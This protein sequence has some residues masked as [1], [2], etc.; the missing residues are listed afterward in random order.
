MENSEE[1]SVNYAYIA[2]ALAALSL[3]FFSG[4]HTF[5]RSN[6]WCPACGNPLVCKASCG[7]RYDAPRPLGVGLGVNRG[8]LDK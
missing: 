5:E 6:R 1:E 8:S 4:M 2:I 3:G 7:G